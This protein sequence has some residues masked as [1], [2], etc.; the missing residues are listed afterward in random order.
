MTI[1]IA[2]APFLMAS[3][4]SKILT[5]RVVAPKGNPIAAQTSVSLL[6]SSLT[7]KET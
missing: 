5:L 3:S 2:F 7:A 4:A 6:P 1:S